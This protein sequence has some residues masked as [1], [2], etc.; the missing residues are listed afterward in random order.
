VSAGQELTSLPVREP[1]IGPVTETT[2]GILEQGGADK[3]V[4]E[5]ARQYA[6]EAQRE[7][8]GVSMVLGPVAVVTRTLT[9]LFFRR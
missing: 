1:Q 5:L 3:A 7:L 2:V 4:I 8:S 9:H 6:S